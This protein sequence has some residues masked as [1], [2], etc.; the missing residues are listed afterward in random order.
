MFWI[1]ATSAETAKQS[2]SKIGKL[3]GL[4]ATQES[5][6]HWLTH[7]EKP[8]LL[9]V[10]NADDPK[11]DLQSLFPEGERG[12]ILVTTTNPNFRVHATVGSIEFAGL[13]E[14]EAAELL[15]LAAGITRPW[16]QATF[17]TAN[18]IANT[19]GSLALAVTQAGALIIQETWGLTDFL[20]FYHTYRN[21]FLSSSSARRKVLSDKH[22]IYSTW[23]LSLHSLEKR[24]TMTS[25]DAIQLLCIVAFFHFENIRVDIFTRA[26]HNRSQNSEEAESRKYFTRVAHALKK[27]LQ[28]PPMLPDF[29]KE[30]HLDLGLYRVRRALQE[31]RSFSLISYNGSTDSF[32]LH[33][34]VHAWARDRHCVGG[35]ALWAR[36][37]LNTLGESIQLPPN[38]DGEAH[39]SFR[40]DILPHLDSCLA[41]SPIKNLDFSSRFWKSKSPLALAL[42]CIRVFSFREEVLLAAKCGY[43]YAERGRFNDATLLL[44][45]VVTALIQSRGVENEIT[46][47]AML[48]LAGTYWGLGRLDEAIDLQKR[49]VEARTKV[50]GADHKETLTAMD[51]LGR[52]YW[53][54]GQYHESLGLQTTTVKQMKLTLGE[55]HPETLGAMDNLGVSLLSWHRFEESLEVHGEVLKYREAS[56]GTTHL[57]TLTTTNNFAMALLELEQFDEAHRLMTLVYE[58]RKSKLGK[59]HPWTLWSYCNLARIEIEMGN[60]KRAE[61]MLVP[62]IEAAKRSLHPNHLGVLMG[63]GQL[64]R[65]LA[66]QGRLKQAEKLT[67]V[68]IEKVEKHRGIEHPDTVYGVYKMAKLYERQQRLEKAISACR[69]ALERGKMR[70]TEKHPLTVRISDYLLKLETLKQGSD[71]L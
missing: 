69:L 22:M 34:V 66:R 8:W 30:T 61:E 51:H 64:A 1:D 40:R 20:D 62:G 12:Y 31:L 25:D 59:E 50:F 15:L 63:C 32:S 26:L 49:V 7:L 35:Q 53:L 6:K 57:D 48:A 39:E 5:G 23:D 52:S 71:I 9:I 24:Q 70:L 18:K 17:A 21:K 27:R 60:C 28:P 38:S 37:A 54:N 2:F 68:T 56:L 14:C 41:V 4:E 65:A 44:A 13:K 43:V 16:D 10:N 29:L 42:Q 58:E 45:E 46:T 11:M 19:L 55:S 36:V 33:P 3:G 47:R 67:L